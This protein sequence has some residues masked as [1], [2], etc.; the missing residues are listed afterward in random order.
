MEE[1]SWIRVE[2]ARL[3]EGKKVSPISLSVPGLNT[4]LRL[5]HHNM[6]T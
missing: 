4:V 6:G 2:A 1:A 5:I 3:V